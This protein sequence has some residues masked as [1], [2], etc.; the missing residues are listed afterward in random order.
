MA[1]N[2]LEVSF[3]N[4]PTVQ[5]AI[6]ALLNSNGGKLILKI[7]DAT[8]QV[9]IS[10]DCIIRKIEQL[11][12][13]ITNIFTVHNNVEFLEQTDDRIILYIRGSSSLCTVNNYLFLPTI[14]QV[15]SVAPAEGDTVIRMLTDSK[16]IEINEEEIPKVFVLDSNCG[17]PESKEVQLKQLKAES[18]K[19]GKGTTELGDRI[20]NNK[21]T[22]YV[23]AFAN[24]LGGRIYCGIT[25]DGV[26][27]GEKVKNKDAIIT[28]VDKAIKKMIWPTHCGKV[29]RGNQWDIF[30]VPV[31]DVDNNPIES[32][33]V[34][35]ISVLPCAGGVFVKEPESYH[36]VNRKVEKMKF[37]IWRSRLLTNYEE[38]RVVPFIL[39]RTGSWSSRN[40]ESGYMKLTEYLENLRQLG[41]WSNIE[42]IAEKLKNHQYSRVNNQLISLFQLAAV[43][44][45]QKDF[46][47]A[48]SY[49]D[50]FRSKVPAAE[51][52]SI[53]EVEERYSAA[54]IERSS[55]NYEESWKIVEIG[56]QKVEQAPPGFVTAAFLLLAGS[57]L[58]IQVNDEKFIGVNKQHKD[59][60][61]LKKPHVELAKKLCYNALQH[62]KCVES[63]EIAKEE[64]KQRVSITL[65]FLYLGSSVTAGPYEDQSAIPN[66]KDDL[67]PVVE[68]VADS[69][70]SLLTLKGT[71]TL[72]YNIC[73]LQLVKSDLHFRYSQISSGAAD[74]FLHLTDA[75]KYAEGAL[76]LANF[77]AFEDIKQPCQS[78]IA[79]LGEVVDKLK[80][81]AAEVNLRER[82]G[83]EE[84]ETFIMSYIQ[85]LG[86]PQISV[87]N[88]SNSKRS[89]NDKGTWC[90][91]PS[92]KERGD[93]RG[94]GHQTVKI[95]CI[96]PTAAQEQIQPRIMK[97]CELSQRALQ[98]RQ[99]NEPKQSQASTS[100]WNLSWED[101]KR[102]KVKELAIAKKKEE[103]GQS[104]E[105]MADISMNW[106][107]GSRGFEEGKARPTHGSK[108]I[109]EMAKRRK[110]FLKDSTTLTDHRWRQEGSKNRHGRAEGYK[111]R[112]E[113]A[114]DTVMDQELRQCRDHDSKKEKT[115]RRV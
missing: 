7:S 18:S 106:R 38:D 49:L 67:L 95:D 112:S 103:L 91:E 25:N 54:A 37:D 56:L 114:P 46:P 104:P 76:E 27:K 82:N 39:K 48:R 92:E 59:F 35:V 85:L 70:K 115:N 43:A 33:F 45:R 107:D 16:I 78:R 31:V 86:E 5:K 97:S 53:F 102:E 105:S 15:L 17:F 99:G 34:I 64:L 89:T 55:G 68:K 2:E 19:L 36:V 113:C 58:S 40:N 108:E 6:C 8:E 29:E 101:Q 41:K 9:K 24:H 11:V 71:D 109:K 20:L 83:Q 3:S 52:R 65:S 44:Y 30:F 21:C 80:P 14:T 93:N 77:R 32:T 74:R 10:A 1:L 63:F 61:K 23:S 94:P 79:H 66:S 100:G 13:S 84:D 28:K 60:A 42:N 73:R 62:L 87:E 57:I 111:S 51:D 88:H 22:N 81:A 110:P 96:Q 98:S 47:K 69:E 12:Q 72:A 75:L 50:E 26:V 90:Q 4:L